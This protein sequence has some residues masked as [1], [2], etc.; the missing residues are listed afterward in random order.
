MFNWFDRKRY[1]VDFEATDFDGVNWSQVKV[2]WAKSEADAREKFDWWAM[3]QDFV[4][5]SIMDVRE[6]GK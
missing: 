4:I 5:Y 3:D 2:V 6:A 1:F